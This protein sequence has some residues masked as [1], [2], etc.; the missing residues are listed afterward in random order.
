MKVASHEALVVAAIPENHPSRG[1]GATYI[2][3]ILSVLSFSPAVRKTSLTLYFTV[4]VYFPTPSVSR[5][6][7]FGCSGCTVFERY[8]AHGIEGGAGS[9]SV[10]LNGI[11]EWF[12][13][14][15]PFC[16]VTQSSRSKQATIAIV[17]E[18]IK[19]SSTIICAFVYECVCVFLS[20]PVEVCSVLMIV[21]YTVII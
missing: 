4:G 14:F 19:Q 18:Y 9:G 10:S 12:P 21:S 8:L 1:H 2:G 17:N 3:A 5:A 7:V 15:S 11:L 6:R 13:Y 16:D 20:N